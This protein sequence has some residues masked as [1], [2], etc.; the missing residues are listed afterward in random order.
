MEMKRRNLDGFRNEDIDLVLDNWWVLPGLEKDT[1]GNQHKKRR[2][3]RKFGSRQVLLSNP[4]GVPD[5][6]DIGVPHGDGD[7]PI[8]PAPGSASKKHTHH[9]DQH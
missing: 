3:R 4:M 1:G 8:T 2:E 6:A 7:D 5:L 9:V